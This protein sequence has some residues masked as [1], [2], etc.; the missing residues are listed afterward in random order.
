MQ[1]TVGG[2]LYTGIPFNGWYAD[3]EVVR[4][5]TDEGRYN[6]L[7]TVGRLLGLDTTQ[8]ASL[9]RDEAQLVINKVQHLTSIPCCLSPL[10]KCSLG[11]C[12]EAES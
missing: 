2:I 8:H 11:W 4:D 7:P 9:W 1:M 3:T 10:V 6:M 12:E 5:L